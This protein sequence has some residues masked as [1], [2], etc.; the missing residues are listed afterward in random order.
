MSAKDKISKAMW[1][2]CGSCKDVVSANIVQA[3]TDGTIKLSEDRQGDAQRLINIVNA[4]IEQAFHRAFNSFMRTVDDVVPVD[5]KKS[6]PTKGR[7]GK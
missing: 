4:S 6:S 3:T 7:P 5:E 2:V 1:N